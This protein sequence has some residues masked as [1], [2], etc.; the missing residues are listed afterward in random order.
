MTGD[1]G[2]PLLAGTYNSRD[3][4]GVPAGDG[5]I[6]TGVLIR[7]DGLH[8][9]T[10]GARE[11]MA[12]LGVRVVVDFRDDAEVARQPDALD[13]VAVER[14]SLPLVTGSIEQSAL[15]RVGLDVLYRSI[16]DDATAHLAELAR[17]VIRTA[18]SG[19]VLI[20]CTA[21]KDRTG[22]ATAVLLLHAGVDAERVIAD[23]ALS[24]G[25]LS[26]EWECRVVA[27]VESLG[28]EVTDELRALIVSS[29]ASTMRATI[30]YLDAAY[31]GASAYL[32]AAGLNGD[33]LAQLR[34]ALVVPGTAAR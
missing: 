13:G 4:G 25:M 23:Y 9:L 33:E 18:G 6:R 8:G 3:L 14:R 27:I 19:A 2:V 24:E 30:E 1:G 11:R 31:G 32:A 16:L 21:G 29:P 26:G 12:E 7:A 28:F 17:I 22:V 34:T 15:D 10:D 20:H 5:A